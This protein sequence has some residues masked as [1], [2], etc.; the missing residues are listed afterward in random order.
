MKTLLW[1]FFPT[2][3]G[4]CAIAAFSGKSQN[5]EWVHDLLAQ[6][7]I[8]ASQ[9]EPTQSKGCRIHK[10]RADSR[11]TNGFR[12]SLFEQQQACVA[13]ESSGPAAPSR[14]AWSASLSAYNIKSATRYRPAWLIPEALGGADRWNNIFPL[15]GRQWARWNQSVSRMVDRVCRD[16]ISAEKAISQLIHRWSWKKKVK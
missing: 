1:T 2:L 3:L 6:V 13:Y 14:K 10:G 8:Q 9:P 15:R 16:R 7:G 12:V 4:I 11:C 5:T